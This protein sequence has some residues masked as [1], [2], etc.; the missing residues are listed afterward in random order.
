M[1]ITSFRNDCLPDMAQLFIQNFS[2]LR[3]AVPVL[4]DLMQNIDH[5]IDLLSG[6]SESCPGVVALEGGS[7]VGYIGWYVVEH[8]RSTDRRCGFCTE[9]A[10]STVEGLSAAVYR[11][12]YREA[13]RHWLDC[14]CAVH[15]LT[16][17]AHDHPAREV[18]FWNGFGLAVVDAIRSTQPLGI[19]PPTGYVVRPATMDDIDALVALELEHGQHY[20]QPPV[21]MEAYHPVD[22]DGLKSFLAKPWNS[23]WLAVAGSDYMGY[24]RFDAD[25]SDSARVVM[26]PD[27]VANTGAFVRPQYRGRRAAA[28]MIDAALAHYAAQGFTRCSV[29][30]ESFNPEAASFWTR[31]FEP[32]CFSVL[33]VP[34]K[35]GAIYASYSQ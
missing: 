22:A 33:R 24:A 16:L 11:V 19:A 15:G 2:K 8:F 7:V 9:W 6:L 12:M 25:N 35:S 29:D 23:I 20:Q 14:G 18:W 27:Q 5:I 21:L 17:L 30:F 31:Y 32:V 1:E 26:A 4:P 10:H 13:A 34:E 28:S 3:A